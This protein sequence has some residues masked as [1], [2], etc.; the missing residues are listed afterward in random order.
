M[1]SVELM[2]LTA[3]L[4]ATL[5]GHNL[6]VSSVTI[7]SRTVDSGGLFIALKGDRFD[8]HEFAQTA[9]DNGAIALVVERQ[10]AV[11]VPQLIVSDCHRALGM[12][13]GLV[14]DKLNP[15]SLALTGSNGKTSVK[16]MVASICSQA[17]QVCYTAGNFNNDIGVPLTLLRLQAGDEIGVFEL[18][19]N[20][21]GEIDYTSSLVRPDIALVN[22]VASAHL[23]GFGSEAGVARAKSEIFNHLAASGTAIINADDP[24]QD[25]MFAAA[26]GYQQ[27]TFAIEN[28]ADVQAKNLTA[29]AFGRFC[30]DCHYGDKSVAINLPLAGR[31]QV[32]N[33]LAAAAMCLAAGFSL[34]EIAQGLTLLQ[35]VKGRMMPV[36]LGRVTLVD[37]S[38]NAN[39]ASVGAAIRWLQ[40][41]AGNR[42]LVLGDLGELG[43][44]AVALHASLGE[45][46]KQAGIEQ[47]LCLGQLSQSASE[48]FGTDHYI[49]F[50]NLVAAL[51]G[52]IKALSGAVTILVKGSRSAAMERVVEAMK[53]AYG[54]GEWC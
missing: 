51:I 37:D 21:I 5:I 44:N 48:A 53:V 17:H 14:R 26:E 42:I 46:A 28:K 2:Q 38:Y 7:D 11:D 54:Q 43:D 16:E 41:M 31:H 18:G 8:G 39:P 25:V 1:I 49:D 27:L 10:L 45:Q 33:A 47:L 3:P 22:N 15:Q 52:A 40:D 35:P 29:D 19:A 20:H 13:A 34:S 50:D 36:E 12:L 32:S 6:T 30:F 4:A 24:Y 9:I 23:E